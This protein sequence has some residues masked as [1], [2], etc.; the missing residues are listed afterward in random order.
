M[1]TDEAGAVGD[2]PTMTYRE[3]A[4][5][6][7]RRRGPMHYQDLTDIIVR[8]GLVRATGT[9]PAMSL[10]AAIASDIK[11]KG[12][13]SDFIRI[14]RGVFGLR[15]W[16]K[17]AAQLVPESTPATADDEGEEAGAAS[18]DAGLRV[19]VPLFPVYSEL[20]YLLRVWP[21]R[22]RKQVTGLQATIN[23]L[24][25]TPQKTVDWADPATW[26]PERLEGADLEL[27]QDIWD[28]SEGI[29]N[30]RYTYGSWLLAQRYDLLREHGDGILQIT[31]TGQDFLG[32]P[33]G[34]AESAIDEA[35]GLVKLLSIVAGNGPARA[36]GLVGEWGDYLSRRS[37]VSA[38]ST[39]KESMRRRLKNLLERDLVERKGNLYSATPNGL[40]YLQ[41]AGDEDSVG[42]ADHHEVWALVRQQ[43]NTVR[44]SLHELLR[45]MDPFAFEHL[46]KRLLEEMNYHNV[47]V[48][49]RSGDGGVDVVG[50]IELGIT[51][52]REVVQ[53]KRHS[54]AIQR[55]DLDVLRGSLYRFNAV[56][57]TIVTTSRFAK[58][59]QEAAFATG[60]API[61]LIDGEKLIDLLV[62]H[63]IGV[64]KRTI[65][66]LEVDVEAVAAVENDD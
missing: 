4:K 5:L 47:N 20:R 45:D 1:E 12:K 31:K 52:V 56:R 28:R 59:T 62:E 49:A 17:P 25:G 33:G 46:I 23:E 7:L 32:Q 2:A 64:R 18:D 44:E 66:L 53:A 60:A 10:N 42:G 35:E 16:H 38:E 9:T 27:A 3:A 36:G 43:E 34:V 24:R 37:A 57:G 55:K 63:C 65:E 13:E 21:G 15:G 26:I 6:F 54:R 19:R 40:A 48:T 11:R 14:R 50:D 8:S 22:P 39:V 51:S 30:P 41:K 58:G 29:V 61:T